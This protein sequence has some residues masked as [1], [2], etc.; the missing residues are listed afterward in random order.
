[1]RDQDETAARCA[2]IAAAVAGHGDLDAAVAAFGGLPD[3]LADRPRLAAALVEAIFRTGQVP[4]PARARA[5]PGLVAAADTDPPA[6]AGWRRTRAA[7]EV[8]LLVQPAAELRAVDSG[9]ALA[10]LDELAAEYAGDPGLTAMIDSGRMALRFARAAQSGD[11]GA[12]TRLPGDLAGYLGR[13]PP[14][15]AGRPESELLTRMAGLLAAQREGVDVT[16]GFQDLTDLAGTLPADSPVRAAF[17]EASADIAGFAAIADDEGDRPSDEQ[18]DAYVRHAGRSGLSPAD[19]AL[20]H[21]QAGTAALWA[22]RETDPGRLALGLEQ[23]RAAVELAGPADPQ[24]PF[25][26]TTLVTGLVRRHELTSRTADLREAADLLDEA[27][28][29]AGGPAHVLWQPINEML[30]QVRHLLGD[31]PD[32]HRAAVEGLRGTVWQ[33]LV[34][35]DLTS[36]TAAVRDASAEAIEVARQCLAAGDP[37]A[38]ITALDAGRGLALFA[39]TLTADAGPLAHRLAEVGEPELAERWRGTSADLSPELRRDVMT[40]LARHDSAVELLDPP[41][42]AEIQQALTDLD[43]DALVYLVPGEGVRP[44][45]AVLAPA[46]GPPSYLTLPSLN[47]SSVP[48]FDRYLS[49]LA[50]RDLGAPGSDPGGTGSARTGPDGDLAACLDEIG[51]WAWDAA[52]RPLIERYLPRLPG[53]PARP[54]RIELIPMGELARI[55]WSAARRP[56]GRYALELIALSQVASARMLVRSAT[57]PAVPLTPTGLVVGDPDGSLPAARLEAYAIRQTFYRGARYLGRRPDGSPSRSGDGTADEVRAWLTSPDPVAGAV[58]HLACHGF[59]ES[60]GARA[61]AYLSLA[62]GDR[63]T[64]EELVTLLAGVPD[65][66]IGLVVLAACRTGLSLNG[67][68]EAYSLG[69]AFLAGGVR[70]V[71]TSQWSVPDEET[72]ALMFM[73]HRGLRVQGRPAWAALRDAQLWMLDEDRDVPDDMP[74]PLRAQIARSDLRAVVA[75][76]A[77]GHWGQ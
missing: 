29:L 44:G 32:F 14:E 43:A 66:A 42:Y 5:L 59:V 37:A 36:T 61:T 75:W 50:R 21:V 45:H 16:T 73:V 17:G 46:A 23:L 10:R 70:A 25:Y 18:L 28:G 22:G 8:Y 24:R 7:A 2:A 41:G 35:P 49:A 52:M 30:G 65:R 62:G 56:D 3:G 67:Y 53:H 64:A 33:A 60:G 72:S 9:A 77:F 74:E 19:R 68:D 69:T 47:P 40:A 55:P 1:M 27:R 31:R 34:Q 76:A 20:L 54:P 51:R 11:A 48:E 58:L 26:L 4:G 71:L 15:T 12:M 38:A 39:A 57:E 13:L 63:L 6:T